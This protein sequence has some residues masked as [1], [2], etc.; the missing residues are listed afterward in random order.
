MN[1]GQ[2]KKI[3]GAQGK[4]FALRLRKKSAIIPESGPFIVVLMATEL[5]C[6]FN[7]KNSCNCFIC[8]S[9]L[10]GKLHHF[11]GNI[12]YTDATGEEIFFNN[13]GE[14]QSGVILANWIIIK[15]EMVTNLL[16]NHWPALMTVKP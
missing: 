11:V 1:R 16:S 9:V 2:R 8:V 15:L 12:H 14:V 13:G 5:H 3:A 6:V 10:L 4:N 7:Y